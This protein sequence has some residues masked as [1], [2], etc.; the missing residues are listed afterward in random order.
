M[1]QTQPARPDDLPLIRQLLQDCELPYEDLTAEH[2]PHFLVMRI[3]SLLPESD[4]NR[5]KTQLLGVVGL[6]P[7]G[8]NGLLRSLAVAPAYRGQNLGEVL[9]GELE[10]KARHAGIG[11]LYVLT[12]TAANRFRQWGYEVADRA[13]APAQIQQ[14]TEFQS[15]CPASAVCLS[16]PL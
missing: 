14:T 7:C 16:K 3:G 6:E 13:S 5:S 8:R 2:L 9:V 11:R 4:L 12:T 1:N 15:L 10:V